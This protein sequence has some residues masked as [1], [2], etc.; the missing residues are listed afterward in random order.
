MSL[1]QV[2][3]RRPITTLMVYIGVFLFGMISLGLLSQE[4]FPPISYPQL[5]VVTPYENAAPEEIETLITKPI[6]EAVGGISGLRKVTSTSKE[7]LSL[8]IAEFS[9]NQN[10][11]FA[12]LSVREKIDLIKERLPR[13]AQEPVVV[14]FNPFELPVMSLSISSSERTPVQLRELSRK[15]FKDEIEKVQ[16]VASASISGGAEEQILVDVDQAKIR[17]AGVSIIDVS[18]AIATANLNFPGGTIKESFYEYLVR[19][20]GEFKHVDEIGQIPIKARHAEESE[21]PLQQQIL[22]NE[23][24]NR[25]VYLRDVATIKRT[26]KDRTSYS[27]F[28][29][30]ENVTISIQKQAQANTIQVSKSI[31]KKIAEIQQMLPKDIKVD[32]VYDQSKFIR[33]ALNG[34]KDAAVQGGFLAFLVL[35]VFLRDF[36][37]S[38]LV[39]TIT[40]ITVLATYTLMYFMGISLNVISLGGVALGVGMLL[41]NAVVVIENVYRKF[42]E[43]P[44]KGMGEAAITGSEEVMAPMVAS[45]LTTVSVF[46]P[47]VFVTGIAGQI[48][49]E[50]AWVVVVT[51]VISAII[52]FT[53][54][55]MLIAKVGVKSSLTKRDV[56]DE[57]AG[58]ASE[59]PTTPFGLIGRA[60]DGLLSV[61]S[62]PIVAIEKAYAKMLPI[63]LDGKW[64]FLFLIFILFM[65]SLLLFTQMD[66]ILLPKVDQKQFMVKVDL[67]VGARIEFTN[68]I[69]QNIEKYLLQNPDVKSVATIAGSS[70]GESTK[71]I[72]ERLGSHQAQI[73]VTVKPDSSLPTDQVVQQVRQHFE[74]S[75]GKTLIKP[76]RLGYMLYDS[77]FKMGSDNDAP[78]VVDIKG[79]RLDDLKRLALE[80]QEKVQKIPGIYSVTNSIAE[81]FPETKIHINKDRASYYKLSVVTIAQ[82][83][84]I[85]IK[86]VTSSKFK[87]EGREIPIRVQLEEGDR[88][89]FSKL[90]SLVIRSPLELDIPLS[91]FVRFERGLGPSEIKR[92]SQ[93]R[94]VQVYAKIYG[95]GLEEIVQEVQRVTAEIKTPDRYAIRLAGESQEVKESF[96]SLQFAFGLSVILVYM[97]MAAQFESLYQP[98]LIM[99]C[100]PLSLIGVSGA[101]WISNT[102]ISVVVILGIILLA[103]I[104][105]N[106]GIILIDYI[107]QLRTRGV[108]IKEAA[109]QAGKT[110]LRPILMTAFSSA[111]GLTPL[112]LGVGE[113]AEL[114]APMAVAVMGGILVATFLTLVVTPALYIGTEELADFVFRRKK[115]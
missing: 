71:E 113:G 54:L 108:A 91:D 74:L 52:A 68:Q 33:E 85:A 72:L 63:F 77:P 89:R 83:A 23:P 40:P 61:G 96:D 99:F 76:A 80:T 41:D 12:S 29:N 18:T 48:F 102:P 69:A 64:F 105:V 98:F 25:L 104:V 103:G 66:K 95:R 26:V 53:L 82:A 45:T 35:L 93:E 114:Q 109:I 34:V 86:G 21:D 84:N 51:Q 28:N 38:A 100:L 73:L 78:I 57:S 60:F 65:A 50:L 75:E 1:P 106:N 11:D 49:K 13:D 5:S 24:T 70:R 19:T 44:E 16:G 27:R 112:A 59:H 39:V 36:K 43:E 87:E 62:K 56:H 58:A 111:I 8:V 97:I 47:I 9:W 46:L 30:L 7:G 32:V 92:E 37:N 22:E 15:W 4:L 6:E 17:A 79:P 3:I 42:R 10:M 115:K 94:T 88:D 81:P 67:P 107:N 14:K 2:S 20:L 101:L 55:P 90:A 110:R 31:K